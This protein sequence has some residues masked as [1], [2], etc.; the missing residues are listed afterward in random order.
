VSDRHVT[1]AVVLVL[2]LDD[3]AD[4]REHWRL[5][6][7]D[8]VRVGTLVSVA[9]ARRAQH[10]CRE[11][12]AAWRTISRAHAQSLSESAASRRRLTYALLAA[13]VL[14]VSARAITHTW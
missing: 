2:P 5:H 3:T 12:C 11:C 13:L 1:I 6:D 8:G 10:R 9:C 4:V 14:Q 7:L